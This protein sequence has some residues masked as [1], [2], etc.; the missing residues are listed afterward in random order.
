MEEHGPT[1][2][3][4][5][6]PFGEIDDLVDRR[7]GRFQV[8]AVIG[9]GGSAVVYRAH[10]PT[11]ERPVALKVLSSTDPTMVARFRREASAQARLTHD[12]ICPVYDVG[13]EHGRCYIA[14][15]YVD[16]ATLGAAAE[17][18]PTEG[19]VSVV[20]DI[21]D[22]LHVAHREGLIHR[23]VKPS[24]ILVST[25]DGEWHG[26][27][28]DFGI[29]LEFAREDLTVEGSTIGTP[30]FM[31]PEQVHADRCGFDRR[32]DVYGLGATLFF[33][34]CGRPPFEGLGYMTLVD[35]VNKEAPA[36]R[37]LRPQVP[38]DLETIVAK[39]LEKDPARRY[40]SAASLAEDLRAFL[41]GRPIAARRADWRYRLTRLVRRNR[42]L[43][44]VIAIALVVVLTV[45]G[46]ASVR[47]WEARQEAAWAE[48]FA[49]DVRE[50]EA[51]VER[52]SMLPK[53]DI[54][55]SLAEVRHRMERIRE[56][57]EEGG[58]PA[59][60]AGHHALGRGHLA[61]REYRQAREHLDRALELGAR[62]P[63]LD[64]ARGLAL[65]RL[66]QQASERAMGSDPAVRQARLGA[67]RAEFREPALASLGRSVDLGPARRAH[68]E[69]L[70]ALYEG[71]FDDALDLAGRALEADPSFH[72]AELLSAEALLELGE[73]QFSAGSLEASSESYARAHA[74]LQRA[75]LIG[76]S[77]PAVYHLLCRWRT[78]VLESAIRRGMAAPEDFEQ[79]AAQ[80][81][82]AISVNPEDAPILASA[83]E[84]HWRW[85]IHLIG[86]GE[87]PTLVLETSAELAERAVEIDPLNGSALNSLGVALSKLGVHE[88][89]TGG[90]PAPS[91]ERAIGAFDRALALEAMGHE[92][93]SNRG[94]AK[95]RMASGPCPKA[96][97]A[98]SG[99]MTPPG[100][101]RRRSPSPTGIPV[102]G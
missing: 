4:D 93:L 40:D 91:L 19:I 79:A 47:V 50:M 55:P 86:V 89:K 65:G 22:A 23:D 16:G 85:G 17:T 2:T 62:T 6:P 35:I 87:D 84:L 94:L 27:I 26:W 42:A 61:L 33:A 44:A 21:A 12:H 34:L 1:I 45:A 60:A 39:C 74:A 66:Y 56:D 97:M 11:L 98:W 13:E 57:M 58:A 82:E 70:I 102:R 51:I 31:A 59:R 69:G 67:I 63:D 25:D 72:R 24:N 53:H 68:V 96:G 48:T 49:T 80:C 101:S 52:T 43:S 71:R 38:A 46:V 36:V 77:D 88:M 99:W 29:V 10:D 9:R 7:V 30:G 54:R 14:M 8:E 75:A 20:A 18:M 15:A 32:T 90:D 100:T 92:L 81:R 28:T 73:S 41:D 83:A 78:M 3:P 37:S 5:P 64:Y 76:R 95:W